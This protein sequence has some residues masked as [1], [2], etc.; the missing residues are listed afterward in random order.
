MNNG[1]FT[2][3][4]PALSGTGYQLFIL[5][6]NGASAG[7]ITFSGFNG[8][9]GP[10]IGTTNGD[11]Y[12]IR[13]TRVNTRVVAEIV[14]LQATS[15]SFKSAE[16]SISVGGL[17]TVAHG[18]GVIPSIVQLSLVCQSAEGGWTAGDTVFNVSPNGSVTT[19]LRVS[20]PYADATNVYV[21]YSDDTLSAFL[22]NN[23]TTGHTFG[24]T[25]SKW[26][27]VI[28]AYVL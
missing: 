28:S 20:Q 22:I 14:S 9:T 25:N 23:K 18:L 10:E 5:V 16:Q 11:E 13:I 26:K 21:R 7:A 17:V 24:I 8:V 4:S 6:T 27:M 3:Q 2:L 15:T 1:S 19:F 12:L